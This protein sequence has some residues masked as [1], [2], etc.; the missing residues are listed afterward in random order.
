MIINKKKTKPRKPCLIAFLLSLFLASNAF[1]QAIAN[2]I[3]R[4]GFS[5]QQA[6]TLG[7]LF[8]GQGI[9]FNGTAYTVISDDANGAD[10]ATVTICAGGGTTSGRGAC[11]SL[12]GNE[13][14]TNPG[15]AYLESGDASTADVFV[16]VNSSNGLIRF[17]TNAVEIWNM[18]AS[19][20]LIQ[21]ATN[22]GDIQFQ[23]AGTGIKYPA[24]AVITPSTSYPTPNAG[25]T[26]TQRLS[27]IAAGA[28]TATFVELPLATISVGESY[29]VLNGSSNP[30]AI[31]PISG[32]SS[33]ALAA[34]TPF[35]CA[36]TLRCDCVAVSSTLWACK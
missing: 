3:Q 14:A 1:G 25:D 7:E 2:K 10:T 9:T 32:N 8:S 24:A 31:V 11:L 6:I 36:T 12:V 22:G 20:V 15:D 28:P 18:N 27:I 5:P 35:S 23:K 34:G 21:N 33:N 26:L 30:V 17:A 19:G 29:S 4:A 16:R 13:G